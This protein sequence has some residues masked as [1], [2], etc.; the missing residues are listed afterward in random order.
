MNVSTEFTI[1]NSRGDTV[2]AIG[3]VDEGHSLAHVQMNVSRGTQGLA[4]DLQN[5]E[6]DI[7]L[8]NIT[9]GA[10]PSIGDLYITDLHMTAQTEIYGH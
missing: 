4:F 10:S 3:A 9:M 2:V 5:F 1:H 6:A 8:N 7:D